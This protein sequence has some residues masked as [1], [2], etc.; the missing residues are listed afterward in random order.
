M[1]QGKGD[2]FYWKW[3]FVEFFIKAFK[4]KFNESWLFY[5][6]PCLLR[7]VKNQH[8]SFFQS[9]CQIGFNK[10]ATPELV[11][12]PI[13]SCVRGCCWSNTLW[14]PFFVPFWLLRVSERVV[15]SRKA[16]ISKIHI[17]TKSGAQNSFRVFEKTYIIAALLISPQLKNFKIESRKWNLSALLKL[18]LVTLSLLR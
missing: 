12:Y 18:T 7:L 6:L 2:I 13:A 14:S 16:F 1:V 5:N 10:N 9:P 15:R 8:F 17:F 4:K 11:I 3:T